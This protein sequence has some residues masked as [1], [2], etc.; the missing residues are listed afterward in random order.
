MSD[1][2]HD[3][4][5]GKTLKFWRKVK[6]VSQEELA[7]RIESAARHISRLE[8]G[9]ARP[10]KIMVEKI[11]EALQLSDRDQV[12]LLFS[13][14][15]AT[16]RVAENIHLPEYASRKAEIIRFLSHND[17]YPSF[18]ID[19]MT[20]NFIAINKS[21]LGLQSIMLPDRDQTKIMNMFDCLFSYEE[22][23]LLPQAWQSSLCN[24]LLSIYQTTLY[25]ENEQRKAWFEKL[26]S[27]KFVPKN[28]QQIAAS[29]PAAGL[30]S[31]HV[32]LNGKPVKFETF[33]QSIGL[34]GPLT[35]S[36]LPDMI[37]VILYPEDKTVDL[38]ILSK[39]Q[40]HPLLFY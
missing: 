35:F 27:S 28:W 4:G 38:S 30:W 29:Q 16:G 21:W 11:S 18:I 6:S 8:K 19:L 1:S 5:F 15:Y 12:N 32:L 39:D 17:P 37:S 13:A 34:R 20:A 22:K 3:N 10:T 24:I 40:T 7:F 26:I 31:I 25:D 36:S 14:G 2:R 9:D 23:E 33:S